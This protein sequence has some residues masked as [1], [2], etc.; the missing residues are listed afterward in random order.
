MADWGLGNYELTAAELE[1]VSERVV[2]MAN[3]HR[4]ETLLDI[5]C[6]TGNAAILAARFRASVTGLDQAP[7]L[8][9]VAGRRADADGL[10]ISFVVGDAVS[11]PFP[12]ASFDVAVSVFGMIFASDPER[13]FAEMV[14]VMRPNG[15]AFVTVW[16]P[17]GAIDALVGVFIRFVNAATGEQPPDPRI[18]WH[19][20]D[21]V[22]QMADAR[23][24]TV[25]FHDGELQFTAGSPQDYLDRNLQN[26]PMSV[27]M[28]PLLKEA[29]TLDA[30]RADA[31]EVL[32]D[33]NEDPG[34]FRVTSNYRIIELRT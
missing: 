12:D 33:G 8:I 9:E 30:M 19:D 13:A 5:A 29:G 22:R 21:A 1:P 16:L 32:M 14:R 25:N 27:G 4:D 6:G 24:A 7:R 10:D 20:K 31:L 11:L 23:G 3:P 34:A 15:R 17:S 28:V 2:A 18:R 26:H